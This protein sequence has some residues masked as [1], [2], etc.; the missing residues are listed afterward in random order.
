LLLKDEQKLLKRVC[1]LPSDL[2]S[3]YLDDLEETAKERLALFE[4]IA[5]GKQRWNITKQKTSFG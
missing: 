2:A 4:S 5:I 3:A 1:A